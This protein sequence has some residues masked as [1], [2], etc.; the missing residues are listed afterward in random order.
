MEKL[1]PPRT[2]LRRWMAGYCRFSAD[3]CG[4]RPSSR[5]DRNRNR[6]ESRVFASHPRSSS[7][8]T[9]LLATVRTGAA[10]RAAAASTRPRCRKCRKCRKSSIASSCGGE[11]SPTK[12]IGI[13]SGASREAAMRLPR[14]TVLHWGACAAALPLASSRRARG[15]SY[16]TRPVRV[17]VGF[18]AGGAVDI[19]ARLIGQCLSERLGQPFVIE[20]RLERNWS[21][22][23][24]TGRDRS[25]LEPRDQHVP[26][27]PGHQIA[28]G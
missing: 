5:Y 21:A 20:N 4:R 1:G 26:R 27:R 3:K 18:P 16:P 14:R 7:I 8:A 12:P 19:A 15:Q 28:L 13:G 9:I 6:I 11:T 25:D 17:I 24:Y 23:R 22:A 10:A 2:H